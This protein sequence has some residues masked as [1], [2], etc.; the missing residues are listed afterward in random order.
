VGKLTATDLKRGAEHQTGIGACQSRQAF[1]LRSNK[2]P[3]YPFEIFDFGNGWGSYMRENRNGGLNMKAETIWNAVQGGAAAVGAFI[4]WFVG[5]IDGALYALIAFTVADYITGVFAAFIRKELSSEVGAKGIIKKLTIYIIVGIGHLADVYL[6]G[7]GMA[8]R[9]A[10]VFFYAA[11]ELV[12]LIE[13][14]AVIG[15]P[16][17]QV[18]KD[19]LAQVKKKSGETGDDTKGE[20]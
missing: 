18:L 8:L 6:L 3:G 1:L 12:S 20:K 16:I 10:L 11:N 2:V 14:S 5:G 17:P 4:G 7:G 19:A 13:N 15:L 9:T